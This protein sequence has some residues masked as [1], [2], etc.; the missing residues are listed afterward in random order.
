MGVGYPNWILEG[1]NLLALPPIEWRM[2][3]DNDDPFSTG[4]TFTWKDEKSR[5]EE[6]T[7]KL[8]TA[9]SGLT[10]PRYVSA[11]R[12]K[13]SGAIIWVNYSRPLPED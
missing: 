2:S 7:I 8:T 13:E 5:T 1:K 3:D 11:V 10:F 9:Y 6:G 12:L 4:H